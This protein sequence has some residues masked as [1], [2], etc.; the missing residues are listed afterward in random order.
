MNRIVGI[1]IGYFSVKNL[2]FSSKIFQGLY[3]NHLFK[4]QILPLSMHKE[5][6]IAQFSLFLHSSLWTHVKA[7]IEVSSSE[8]CHSFFYAVSCRFFLQKA[9]G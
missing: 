4:G 3:L 2:Y 6:P 8:K 1:E 7:L 5:I 9:L